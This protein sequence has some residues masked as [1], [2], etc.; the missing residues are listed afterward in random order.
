MALSVSASV[1][2]STANFDSDQGVKLADCGLKWRKLEVFVREDV[3]LGRAIGN[4]EGDAGLEILFE[5]LEL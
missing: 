5:G 3:I 4:A 1:D 2:G